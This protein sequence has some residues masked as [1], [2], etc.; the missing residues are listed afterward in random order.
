MV[1]KFIEEPPKNILPMQILLEHNPFKNSVRD[2]VVG[3]AEKII[4]RNAAPVKISKISFPNSERPSIT[5]FTRDNIALDIMSALPK[6]EKDRREVYASLKEEK[7]FVVISY[8]PHEYADAYS[9]VSGANNYYVGGKKDKIDVNKLR[10]LLESYQDPK[11]SFKVNGVY[12]SKVYDCTTF[13]NAA[14]RA[15]GAR[16][17]NYNVGYELDAALKKPGSTIFAVGK[18]L[19]NKETGPAKTKEFLA[20]ANPGDIVVFLRRVDVEPEKEKDFKKYYEKNYGDEAIN[21]DGVYYVVGHMGLYM[22][23]SEDGDH[24]VAQAHIYT[25]EVERESLGK[26][27]QEHPKTVG[28]IAIISSSFLISK[29]KQGEFVA[30]K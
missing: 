7:A 26:Y 3:Y 17:L 5:V 21:H 6:E 20:Q 16:E 18:D 4:E 27:I 25:G 1:E 29:P 2:A 22:G 10:K 8:K 28:A 11:V 14:L 30:L 9:I 12:F 24:K 15:G 19:R 13:V 23:K